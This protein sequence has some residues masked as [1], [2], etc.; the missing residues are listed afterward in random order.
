VDWS[1]EGNLALLDLFSG[2]RRTLTSKP[3]GDNG[4]TERSAIST[5]EQ[6]IAYSWY[7]SARQDTSELRTVGVDGAPPRVVYRNNEGITTPIGWSPDGRRVL[8]LLE[9]AS[10]PDLT[11]V[12]L[13]SGAAN[14]LVKLTSFPRNIS[15]SPDGGL[16]AYDLASASDSADR[17][18][19]VCDAVTGRPAPLLVQPANDLEPVWTPDGKGVAFSSNR[20]GNL[21]LWYVPVTRTGEAAGEPRL[22]RGDMGRFS[23]IG[24]GRDAALFYH[25]ITGTVDVYVATVDLRAGAISAPRTVATHFV[26]VNLFSDW[27]SDGRSLVFTSRRGEVG[28]ERRSQIL[29]IRDLNSNDERVIAPDLVNMSTPRWSPDA[30]S[31]VVRGDGPKGSGIY[32]VS[33]SNGDVSPVI[34]RDGIVGYLE[35]RP[36]GR[37]LL[38]VAAGPPRASVRELTLRNSAERSIVENA[39]LFSVSRNGRQLAFARREPD[40]IAIRVGG[41]DGDLSNEVLKLASASVV[42]FAGWSPDGT[43]LVVSRRDRA[44]P[45]RQT[46]KPTEILAVSVAGGTPR[47]LA[48]LELDDPRSM[49][50]SPDGTSLA[51]EVGYPAQSMWV[52][53]QFL[54]R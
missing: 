51:F 37:A 42:E 54:N 14:E 17:D 10:G 2:T 12:D 34:V 11:W 25:A 1:A 35:W 8:V 16:V 52:L 48:T 38:F 31:I 47:R 53:E 22:V 3:D 6:T 27:S 39:F 41:A 15:L 23:P 13:R 29:V 4:F 45:A 9:R 43:E 46:P 24:F 28:F 21:G 30:R 44:R 36:D 26:G 5:D 32:R 7:T 18:L 50:L 19:F 33:A 40:G 49:R 20:G